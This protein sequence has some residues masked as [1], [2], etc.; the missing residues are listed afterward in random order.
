MDAV[1]IEDEMFGRE[2][3]INLIR[4]Y[5][6]DITIVGHADDVESG[7]KIIMEKNPQ[8]VFLDIRLGNRSG[9]DVIRQVP[10][11]NF[12][13]VITSAYETYALEA[14][15]M[16]AVD[17]LLKPVSK[18]DLLSTLQRVRQQHPSG[19]PLHGIPS[20]TMIEPAP[21]KIAVP[22]G[23]GLVFV[24]LNQ[25][26]R[27]EADGAYTK[28]ILKSALPILTTRNLGEYEKILLPSMGFIRI[29]HSVIV[30]IREIIRYIR[31]DG[32]QVIM[33]DGVSVDVSRRKKNEFL[34]WAEKI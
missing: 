19:N 2:A 24:A 16:M 6:S 27:C 9:F 26:L 12:K 33:T 31:G 7:V 25:L 1:I 10:T 34:E 14:F 18:E 23:N 17:Y 30:N 11:H 15:K 21:E 22:S 20:A 29:H 8:L 28:L 3:L 13:L 32:G 5:A 4:S